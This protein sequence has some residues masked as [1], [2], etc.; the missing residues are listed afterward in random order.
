MLFVALCTIAMCH[1]VYAQFDGRELSTLPDGLDEQ[2]S[3][4]ELHIN[5]C[6][7]AQQLVVSKL[8]N[9]TVLEVRAVEMSALCYVELISNNERMAPD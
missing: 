6:S 5:S 2:T 4:R 7:A 1:A 8:T 9:L 3:L